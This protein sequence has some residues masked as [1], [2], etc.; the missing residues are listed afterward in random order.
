MTRPRLVDLRAE[1]STELLEAFI[2]LYQQTF[3]DPTEREDPEPWREQLWGDERPSPQP[4][5]HLLAAVDPGSGELLGG[6][7]FEHYRAS[8]CGL[9]TY[10]VIR[11]EHRRQGHSRRLARRALEILRAEA[12]AV[13]EPLH[14]VFAEAENPKIVEEHDGGVAAKRLDAFSRLGA[15]WI[16]IPYV[17]PQLQGGSARS[18]HLLLLAMNTADEGADHLD[19]RVVRD[20]L[21]EFYRALGVEKPDADADFAAMATALRPPR[22]RL[23][24][25]PSAWHGELPILDL[26]EVSVCLHFVEQPKLPASRTVYSR[27]PDMGSMELDLLAY[28]YRDEK[29]QPFNSQCETHGRL[30]I[31]ILF[32]KHFS[33]SSEGRSEVLEAAATRRRAEGVVSSTRFLRSGIRIW[34]LVLTPRQGETFSELDIIKLIHLYDGR[35]EHTELWKKIRFRLATDDAPI[36]QT[37]PEFDAADLLLELCRAR[38]VEDL[39]KL[40][41][42]ARPKAGTIQVIT[43][44]E[45]IANISHADLLETMRKAR[46]SDDATSHEQMSD[47]VEAKREEFQVLSAYCGLVTGI[48]DFAEIGEEEILDTL[49]PTFPQAGNLLRIHRGTLISLAEHDRVLEECRASVG[50]SPYLILPHA[51]LLHN[52]ALV[53]RVDAAFEE[54]LNNA[55]ASLTELEAAYHEADRDLNRLYLQ[56][57][58]NYVTER[59]LY[60]KGGL[61]RGSDDKLMET[62]AKMLE[63]DTRIRSVWD[64]RQD[65]GQ[66]LIQMLLTLISIFQ[67]KGLLFELRGL[68]DNSLEGWI[69]LVALGLAL[70]IFLACIWNMGR[71]PPRRR[72]R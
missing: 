4:R 16:D 7:V 59:V 43:G 41:R 28:R 14:A 56:N 31:E 5:F 36:S 18:R 48:F 49:E 20:F 26:E 62:R 55:E 72:G 6:I 27:C 30:E 35:N 71:R 24:S 63:L 40:D 50:I 22:L 51:V 45:P 69:A 54:V 17:Q 1:P 15:R 60:D 33:Y 19:G 9:L 53:D 58:F 44:R 37:S 11:P 47:W 38:Q 34:H 10:L 65:W 23:E 57:V 39:P 52:E 29:D 12:D 68:K 3:V 64:S 8:R 67:L 25:L 13:G 21:H 70:V 42:A 46:S 32:P 61:A 2:A 66:M